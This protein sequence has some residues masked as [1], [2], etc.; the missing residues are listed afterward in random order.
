MMRVW[1]ESKKVKE[2]KAKSFKVAIRDHACSCP[3]SP[4]I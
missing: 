1:G 2:I 3:A 4:L